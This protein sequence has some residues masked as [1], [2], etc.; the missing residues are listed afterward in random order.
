MPWFRSLAV[1]LLATLVA[2]GGDWPQWLGPNRDGSTAEKVAPWKEAPK[3]LWRQPAGEGNGSPVITDGR[4]FL[5][6]KVADKNEE[7][8]S[9]FDASTGKPIWSEKYPRVAFQSKFGNGPRATPAVSGNHVYTFGI[10]GVLSC[11]EAGSGKRV[12]QVDTLKKFAAPNL[13][14]GVA[15]SP[16]VEG[17]RIL[18]NIGGKGSSIVAF[19]KDKGDVAWKCLDDGASY[20]SPIALGEGKGRQII[21]LTALGVVSLSPADGS[22][23]WRFPLKD[24]L[25]ESST[26][27]VRA[28]DYLLASSITYGSAG[29]HLET[30]DGKPAFKEAWKNPALTCYFSTPVPVGTEHIYI[31]TGANP[32][33]LKHPEATLRCI[34]AKSGKELWSKPKVGKY[35]ASLLRTGDG[36]LLML[37]DSGN[38]LLLDPNSKEYRELARSKVCGETWAH[39]ALANGKLYIRDQKELICLQIPQDGR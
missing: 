19:D 34:E 11:F 21:F 27:P 36:K 1:L 32:L 12:W 23:F 35:H 7:Q 20:S 8:V 16:L 15:C 3:V 18:L 39:P 24:F 9:A 31:V 14:F 26:T 5:H 17:N 25:F 6:T 2:A 22:E 29:L 30:R 10:T 28:G 37:D 38:L 33:A 4:V 13:T